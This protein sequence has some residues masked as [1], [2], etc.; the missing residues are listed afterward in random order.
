MTVGDIISTGRKRA[1]LTQ[2][3]L[4]ARIVK[5]DGV[6]IS[7]PYLNDLEHDRR[8]ASPAPQLLRQFADALHLSYEYLLFVAGQLPDDLRA[9]PHTPEEVEAAF[10]AFR[11]SLKERS[12]QTTP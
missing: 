6:P 11:R 7:Q 5:E 3:E 9:E 10:H 8:G 2:K 1:G 12:G 4:A